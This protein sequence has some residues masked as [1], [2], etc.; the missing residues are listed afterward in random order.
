MRKEQQH[1]LSRAAVQAHAW[2]QLPL[3]LLYLAASNKPAIA[4]DVAYWS[5]VQGLTGPFVIRFAR[6][7]SNRAFR[8]VFYHRLKCGG[9]LGNILGRLCAIAYRPMPT[10]I[11]YTRDIGPGLFIQHGICTIIAARRIGSGCW[12][13]K[14]VTIGYTDDTSCPTLGDNVHVGCGAKILGNVLVGNNVKVGAN[15]VVVK[16][17]PDDCTVVG[18]PARIVKMKGQRIDALSS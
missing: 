8:T 10:L 7:L 5:S 14:Q 15:A 9:L 3:A 6:L 16:G 18:V 1:W 13:N 11:I 4:G 12:I 17:V 2:L